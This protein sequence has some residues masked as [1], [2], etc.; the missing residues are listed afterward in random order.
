MTDPKLGVVTEIE[1]PNDHSTIATYDGF[2]RLLG[3]ER[4]T[5]PS[6]TDGVQYTYTYPDRS[7]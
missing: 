7:R 1:D 5:D 3:V 2:G 4:P 6:G